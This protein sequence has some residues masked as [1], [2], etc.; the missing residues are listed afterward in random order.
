MHSKLA[1]LVAIGLGLAGPGCDGAD[2]DREP[3]APRDVGARAAPRPSKAPAAPADAAPPADAAAPGPVEGPADGPLAA[4]VRMEDARRLSRPVVEQLLQDSDVVTRRRTLL[5]LGRIGDPEALGPLRGA[6]TDSDGETRRVALTSL[7]MLDEPAHAD[8]EKVLRAFLDLSQQTAD[9]RVA[10]ES[11]GRAGSTDAVGTLLQALE[12]PE[13]RM[14]AS[15]A[16]ALGQM[17]MREGSKVPGEQAMVALA[18][19]LA[20]ADVGVRLSSAF[21]LSRGKELSD[22]ARAS[23]GAALAKALRHDA[24][25]EVRIMAGRAMGALDAGGAGYLLAALEND[26][27]WR[28]RTAAATALGRRASPRQRERGLAIAW[29]RLAD[30]PAKLVSPD[31][32]VL[33]ALLVEAV[34]RPEKELGR[35]LG[36][37]EGGAAKLLAASTDQA[38]RLALA[39]VQCAAALAQDRIKH[40]PARVSRCATTDAP[41]ITEVERKL[42]VARTLEGSTDP[43]VQKR[44]R[45]L[46]DDPEP[47]VRL[48]ALEAMASELTEGRLR[49]VEKALADDS[50]AVVAAMAEKLAGAVDYYYPKATRPAE[51]LTIT[52]HTD[53]GPVVHKMSEPPVKGRTLPAAALTKALE[54]VDADADVETAID[55]L[56]AAGALKVADAAPAAA[57]FAGHS[58]RSVR[59]AARAALNALERDPG[60]E[61][62]PDPPNLVDPAA[63]AR[64]AA[65]TPSVAVE[66]TRGTFVIQLRPDVAP[67]TVANFLALVDRGFYTGVTFHRVVPGFVA[68]TGDPTATGYGGPG[69][70]IRDELNDLPY[71]R[72]TVGMAL[73]GHDTGGSQFF[74]TYGAQPHLDRQYTAFGR[75][76]DGQGVVDAL[77]PWDTIVRAAR[78]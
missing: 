67:A 53:S 62:R 3:P 42:L 64:L 45:S 16:V 20:D 56:K 27:D 12:S 6:L 28:V 37:V 1:V 57:R 35:A 7:G 69:Y 49:F 11:L 43:G 5:A 2:R 60:P 22:G 40:Q 58:N 34:A 17:A 9:R 21:A 71:E 59:R 50:P 25:A 41:L 8:A 18:S 30:D 36:A 54:R 65:E 47:R 23:I 78:R 70:T 44:L 74:I 13:P 61:L 10:I 15:A 48:A 77:Q 19:H 31:L 63:L 26:E 32:H 68:Q 72:G 52:E 33:R 76:V 39:H 4:L 29:K 75:V 24:E 51:Q 55:L 66:T 73:A 38:T 46:A 14:R